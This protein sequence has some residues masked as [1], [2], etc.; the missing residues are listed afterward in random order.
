LVAPLPTGGGPA[1]KEQPR[2]DT[3]MA[4]QAARER[5]ARATTR[6]APTR[7]LQPGD[8]ICGDCGEGNPP[9]RKFCSRCGGSLESAVAVKAPWWRKFV[10][11]RKPKVLD[12]GSRPGRGGVRTKSRRAAALAK[13]FPTVRKVVAVVLLVSGIAYGT[14]PGVR[15]W[16]NDRVVHAKSRV[17]RIINPQYDP[18]HATGSGATAHVTGHEA[19]KAVDGFTNTYWA[20]PSPNGRDVVLVLLFDHK[21]DVDKAIVYSGVAANF[22]LGTNRPQNLHIV[23]DTGAT[24]DVALKDSPDKQ[25]VKIGKGHGITRMEIHITSLFKAVKSPNVAITEIELFRKE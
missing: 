18:V 12:A 13:V 10:P 2:V 23:Y 16:V 19:Q 3:A 5:T 21:V 7:R 4:P 17:T 24:Y 25:E 1:T 11:K 8:L 15:G 14:L 20:A 22:Q 9:N 6:Q